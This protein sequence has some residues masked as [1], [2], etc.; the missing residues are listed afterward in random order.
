MAESS[1]TPHALLVGKT[2]SGKSTLLRRL[3]AVDFHA[4]RGLLLVDPHGDLAEQVIHDLPRRR[5]NDLAAFNATRAEACPGLNPLRGV[6]PA[7]R[8]LVV[9]TVLA[10]FRKTWPEFWGPRLEHVLRHALLAVS[11]VRSA[12][13]ACAQRMLVDDKHRRWVLKQVRDPVSL[14]F[15]VKEFPGYGARLA[16]EATAPVLNK[17]GALLSSPV[18][19]EI[20]TKPRPVLDAWRCMDRGRVVIARLPKGQIGEDAATLLGGLLLGAF[21]YAT[22]ARAN[23]PPAERRPFSI[24]VDEVASFATRPFVELLAEA[25]KFGVTLVLAT[26]SLAAMDPETRAAILANVGTLVCFRV[27]A[28]DAEIVARE[29]AGEFR[30]EQLMD[31][32]VGERVVRDGNRRALQLAA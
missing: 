28:D 22:T 32:E 18:V 9:S 27:G 6:S 30:P 29:L 26:Q 17:L 4:G 12:T 15:W 2:G 31:L 25:R 16:A 5:R 7:T 23:V 19:R 11:E 13:L 14:Q 8:P 20:V 24:V 10:T 21:Q 1:I 3:V